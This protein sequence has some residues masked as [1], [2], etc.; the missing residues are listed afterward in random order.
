MTSIII[1]WLVFRVTHGLPQRVDTLWVGFYHN[2]NTWERLVWESRKLQRVCVSSPICWR[3][4]GYAAGQRESN[5][6]LS[7]TPNGQLA[8][9]LIRW[10]QWILTLAK[11]LIWRLARIPCLRW[12]ISSLVFVLILVHILQPETNQH[13]SFGEEIPKGNHH[14]TAIFM[15][16]RMW[17]DTIYLQHQSRINRCSAQS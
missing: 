9:N 14:L 13:K 11:I 1:Q 5:N 12:I 7:K 10:V 2:L 3:C 17:D 16:F 15:M 4:I 6:S 8:K